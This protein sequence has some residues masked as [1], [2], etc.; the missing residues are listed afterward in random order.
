MELTFSL[1]N[2]YA[3]IRTHNGAHRATCAFSLGVVEDHVLV[4]LIVNGLLLAHQLVRTDL[5]A[6]DT[7]F[8]FIFV[9]LYCRQEGTTSFQLNLR[10]HVSRYPSNYLDT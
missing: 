9:D 2:V 5:N 8:T 3:H 6:Q 7:S 10:N 1:E 4:P